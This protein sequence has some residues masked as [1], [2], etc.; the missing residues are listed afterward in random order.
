MIPRSVTVRFDRR[1]MVGE[2]AEGVLQQ[3][4]N[5]VGRLNHAGFRV[6]VSDEAVTTY[7]GVTITP[8]RELA[9]WKLDQRHPLADAA[10]LAI[11][12]AGVPLSIGAFGV[13]T[14]G[15][16]SAG[17]RGIPTIGIGPGSESDCHI[18]DES[19]AVAEIRGAADIYRHLCLR[20][21]GG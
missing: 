9:A 1:T 14:N 18:I 11:E 6:R 8:P 13:C 4:S 12:D 19:I 10:R 16:E 15:S 2:T 20:V 21:A 3:I 17:R 5:V 7:T